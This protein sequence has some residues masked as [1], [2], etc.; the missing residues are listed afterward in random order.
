MRPCIE[1]SSDRIWINGKEIGLLYRYKWLSGY[2]RLAP[3]LADPESC[4]S[5]DPRLKESDPSLLV[6]KE[7]V[8]ETVGIRIESKQPDPSSKKCEVSIFSSSFIY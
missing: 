8:L 3:R 4:K 6:V 5:L 7:L 1:G 2:P